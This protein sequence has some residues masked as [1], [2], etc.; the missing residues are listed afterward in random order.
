MKFVKG[1]AIAGIVITL[2]NVIGG[3]T[4]GMA[5]NGMSAYD[6][7]TTYSLLLHR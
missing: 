7:A 5:M 1:D 4:I 2:I 6:S 3:I